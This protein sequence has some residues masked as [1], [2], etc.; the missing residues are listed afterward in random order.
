MKLSEIKNRIIAVKG[1]LTELVQDGDLTVEEA[2][3][4]AEIVIENVLSGEY[5]ECEEDIE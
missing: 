5:I 2:K 4:I 3:D 1:M